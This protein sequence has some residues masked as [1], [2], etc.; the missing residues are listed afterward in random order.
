MDE[1]LSQVDK[2]IQL[3]KES[4]LTVEK[5]FSDAQKSLGGKPASSES[6]LELARLSE[7]GTLASLRQK[8][9]DLEN[10][11]LSPTTQFTG[12]VEPIGVSDRPVSPKKSLLTLG[13]LI[14]GGLAGAVL[15]F[16]L[17]AWRAY[18]RTKHKQP[19]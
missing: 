15:A 12:L 11:K 6:H 13:G 7:A 8:V 2:S 3:A 16:V 1:R 14:L 9:L 5:S 4:L 19:G 17:P 18:Q 10:S